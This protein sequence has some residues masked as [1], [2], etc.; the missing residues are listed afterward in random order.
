MNSLQTG[1]NLLHSHHIAVQKV[2]ETF[3]RVPQSGALK[4]KQPAQ[5]RLLVRGKIVGCASVSRRK[6][7]AM[8]RGPSRSS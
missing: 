4:R 1:N 6:R 2:A 8:T 5:G 7:T 3:G